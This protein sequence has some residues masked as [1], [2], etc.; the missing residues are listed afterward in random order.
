MKKKIEAARTDGKGGT[1]FPTELSV[2]TYEKTI[3]DSTKDY[4][5]T[6]V[7]KTLAR[8]DQTGFHVFQK[9]ISRFVSEVET[10]LVDDYYIDLK[11]L[12]LVSEE[13]GKLILTTDLKSP[14]VS[15]D[16]EDPEIAAV[17]Y[18]F[19]YLDLNE[20]PYIQTGKSFKGIFDPP[21]WTKQISLYEHINNVLLYAYKKTSWFFS[22]TSWFLVFFG[23]PAGF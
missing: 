20:A 1:D 6:V 13:L 3:F 14:T 16:E 9:L 22:K 12:T 8:N 18:T 10:T 11:V 2:R 21:V 5:G 7:E 23:K 17:A 4:V 19:G 15:D